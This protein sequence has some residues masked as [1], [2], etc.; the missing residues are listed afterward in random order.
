MSLKSRGVFLRARERA[1]GEW[2]KAESSSERRQGSGRLRAAASVMR[3]LLATMPPQGFA[4][5]Q[6]GT[7]TKPK[8]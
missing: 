1:R 6:A 4:Q 7:P 8:E 5:Q 2:G 3:M